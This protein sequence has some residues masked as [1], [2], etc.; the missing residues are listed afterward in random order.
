[1]ARKQVLK[2]LRQIMKVKDFVGSEP[3][4]AYII[5]SGDSHQVILN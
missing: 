5:P 3:I 4:H 2:E 1:M